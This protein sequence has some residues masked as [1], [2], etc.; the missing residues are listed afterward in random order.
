MVRPKSRRDGQGE[1]EEEF[2]DFCNE[3]IAVLY[4]RVDTAKLCLPCDQQV[5]SA[6]ALS[7]KHL[8]SQICDNCGSEPASVRC[9]TDQLA[10][11]QDCDWEAHSTCSVSAASHDRTLLDGFSGCPTAL[12]LA[13]VWGLDL[14]SKSPFNVP[15]QQMVIVNTCRNLDLWELKSESMVPCEKSMLY[16]PHVENVMELKTQTSV[17]RKQV[18]MKQLVELQKRYLKGGGGG[19]GGG[20][21]EEGGG[22]GG[23]DGAENLLLVPETPSHSSWRQQGDVV[24]RVVG[25]VENQGL[26]QCQ[27]ANFTSLLTMTMSNADSMDNERLLGVGNLMWNINPSN[28]ATQIWDFNLGRMRDHEES[29]CL[30]VAYRG[31]QVGFTLNS[32]SE[33]LKEPDVATSKILGDMYEMNCSVGKEDVQTFHNNSN[34]PT[35]SQGLATSGNNNLPIPK[36]SSGGSAFGKPRGSSGSKDINFLDQPIFSTGESTIAATA[37]A[38]ME[39]LA[40]NR[41]DAMKRYREKKKTRRYDKHIRY[42]SRKARADTRK[43]VKGRFVK[44]SEAPIG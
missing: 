37:K 28:Q 36:P 16:N 20:D 24:E 44:A 30:E 6:N 40:Q 17:K 41:G 12:E 21:D 39:M 31:K 18:I 15:S 3:R 38:N 1:G 22:P 10:L 13:S 23:G 25:H 27:L 34:N 32:C 33:L 42:E 11:C 5:H 26:Q 29:G 43:R 8:R 7:R 2:C 35:A 14:D 9:S 4:C 19:G